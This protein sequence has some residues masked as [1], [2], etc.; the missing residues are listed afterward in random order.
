MSREVGPESDVM[1]SVEGAGVALTLSEMAATAAL[2]RGNPL[3]VHCDCSGCC[4]ETE[5]G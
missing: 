5:R 4:T 3:E 1:Q 2:S